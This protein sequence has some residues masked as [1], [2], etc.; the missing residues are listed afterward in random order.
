M[1]TYKYRNDLLIKDVDSGPSITRMPCTFFLFLFF[2][3][4][5]VCAYG[6]KFRSELSVAWE[7]TA[8]VATQEKWLQNIPLFSPQERKKKKK[9][10]HQNICT[11]IIQVYNRFSLVHFLKNNTKDR[12]GCGLLVPSP[13]NEIAFLEGGFFFFLPSDSQ[14]QCCICY[15]DDDKMNFF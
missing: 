10:R 4:W 1:C 13:I 5:S 15:W 12:F 8:T 2:I 9:K 7:T 14:H 6:L 11:L 3:Y